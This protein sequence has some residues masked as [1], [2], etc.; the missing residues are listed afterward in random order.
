MEHLSPSGHQP[1]Y[2]GLGTEDGGDGRFH[3]ISTPPILDE[4]PRPLTETTPRVFALTRQYTED[5]KPEVLAYG[6]TM[7]GWATTVCPTGRVTGQWSSAERAASML[8]AHLVWI[9]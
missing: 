7:S 9:G 2:H 8:D 6:M 5:D 1:V 3:T 4:D